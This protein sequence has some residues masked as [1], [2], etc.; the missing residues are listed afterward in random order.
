MSSFNHSFRVKLRDARPGELEELM[1]IAV[2]ANVRNVNLPC[3]EYALRRYL[4][5]LLCEPAKGFVLVAE[6]GGH[7]I[8]CL[9]GEYQRQQWTGEEVLY[10]STYY[11]SPAAPFKT[12]HRLLKEALERAF[13]S[14]I[15]RVI[16]ITDGDRL[17][18]IYR[19]LGA[20]MATVLYTADVVDGLEALKKRK[21]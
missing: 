6:Q 2:L 12:A 13:C 3:P 7:L 8:G 9:S 1:R 18:R 17:G 16:G 21:V 4:T 10:L 5:S 19:A 15:F 14:G 20:Q 11:C